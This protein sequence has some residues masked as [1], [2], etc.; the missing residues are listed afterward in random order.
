MVV[1][2]SDVHR[3]GT[4]MRS[5]D[6]HWPN[7]AVA[8]ALLRP[9]LDLLDPGTRAAFDSP[10]ASERV[11]P[12]GS[13]ILAEG[14]VPSAIEVV[15]SGWAAR[16]KSLGDGRR[17]IVS[18]LLP[19]DLIG[20]QSEISGAATA[21][22]EAI[23]EVRLQSGGSDHPGEV[24]PWN[25]G[26]LAAA[27]KL[28]MEEMLL[29]IGQRDAVE[30][31]AALLLDLFD[32]AAA[33]QMVRAG[34]LA[35]PLTQKHLSEALGITVIHV[36][37]VIGALKRAAIIKLS[38]KR[39]EVVDRDRLARAAQ[40]SSRIP[41]G[42]GFA[43]TNAEKKGILIVEDEFHT[44]QY[45]QEILGRMDIR[46]IGPVGTLQRAMILAETEQFD[47]ALLDVR[48]RH[49][50]K[51]YPVVELLRRRKIPFS[52]ITAYADHSIDRFPTDPVLRKPFR[53]QQ[54]MST[55]STLI[56]NDLSAVGS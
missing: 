54:L 16:Y 55:V 28:R 41:S 14:E 10:E 2:D 19:G 20:M 36:N 9:Q 53:E 4:A 46:V 30:R 34:A 42:N 29:S 40:K 24:I 5:S 21:T 51:V 49:S 56:R 31:T 12:A 35:V 22:I 33:R 6:N 26:A 3:R 50:D 27:Q 32:R 48:L 13:A 39:L 18:F 38:H 47:A 25:L 7:S 15:R 17:Q 23:T 11:I 52:F 1:R 8:D 44:A 37:R 43:R 45:I